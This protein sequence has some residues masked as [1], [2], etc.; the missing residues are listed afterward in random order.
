MAVKAWLEAYGE[1]RP[2][3]AE[4]PPPQQ[5]QQQP[6][7]INGIPVKLTGEF[8]KKARGVLTAEVECDPGAIVAGL[9]DGVNEADMDVVAVA[10]GQRF[11]R[12]R[13][14][15]DG[16]L[17]AEAIPRQDGTPIDCDFVPA[18]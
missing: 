16:H 2:R 14:P 5:Q 12:A 18:Y 8:L 17:E 11:R 15:R 1:G 4:Q 9:A 3:V 6:E 13:L 10:A 7:R